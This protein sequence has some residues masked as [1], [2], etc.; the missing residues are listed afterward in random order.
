MHDVFAHRT[1]LIELSKPE[2]PEM[3]VDQSEEE[4][5]IQLDAW[6]SI[7]PINIGP[8]FL[9]E[10]SVF[11]SKCVTAFVSDAFKADPNFCKLLCWTNKKVKFWNT[12][13]RR[14][15]VNQRK[16]SLPPEE[17]IHDEIVMNGELLMGYQ[18]YIDGL[19]NSSEYVVTDIEYEEVTCDFGNFINGSPAEG[20]EFESTF[21]VYNVRLSNDLEDFN[22]NIV[23]PTTENYQKFMP[24]FTWYLN[25]GKFGRKWPM[26]YGWKKNYMLLTDI[27]SVDKKLIVK[28]DV[29][30][31]YALSTHKSQG[32]TYTNVF[33]DEADIDQLENEGFVQYLFQEERGKAIKSK[34]VRKFDKLYPTFS[35]YWQKMQVLKNKLKYV[36]FSRPVQKAC[37]FTTKT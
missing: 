15:M 33:V 28:K 29:D 6:N 22:V 4:Y 30:Y 2:L 14:T 8:E 13:I 37:I 27:Y 20:R 24:V 32:S 34:E 19:M 26:Y 18:N 1:N 3:T 36:A 12:Q 31:A 21:A 23:E 25:Q 9:T 16:K 10:L 35:V 11:G 7:K 5:D 17:T